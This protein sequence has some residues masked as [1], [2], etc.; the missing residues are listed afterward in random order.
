MHSGRQKRERLI[1]MSGCLGV[2]RR[3]LQPAAVIHVACGQP[4]RAA[5][6]ECPASL[7]LVRHI[8]ASIAEKS[9]TLAA[10]EE[11]RTLARGV[12]GVAEYQIHIRG[13]RCLPAR[14]VFGV[15]RGAARR[16][17]QTLTAAKTDK[18]PHLVGLHLDF[19]RTFARDSTGNSPRWLRAGLAVHSVRSWAVSSSIPRK[20]R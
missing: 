9:P 6:P 14:F 17:S 4:W 16:R 19:S 3:S 5:V 1:A 11:Q 7:S 18:R 20:R 13:L 10:S 8:G 15:G 12:I 2:L